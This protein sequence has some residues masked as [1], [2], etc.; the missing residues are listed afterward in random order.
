MMNVFPIPALRD[1]YIWA[2]H[3]GSDAL[4]VDPGVAAPV[5]AWLDREKMRLAAILITHHHGDHTGGMP[6]LRRLYGVPVMGPAGNHISGIDHPLREGDSV[7]PTEGF[8]EFEAWAVPGHTLDHIAYYSPG[9]L[10]CGDTLFSGGCGRLFEGNADQLYQA[11]SRFAALPGNTR[12]FPAHE[13]TA[14]NLEFARTVLPA[15]KKL[16][17]ALANTLKIRENVE[18]TLPSTV[19]RERDIN[20]FMRTEEPAVRAA[21]EA[22]AGR[23]L[24][25]G[26]EVLAALRQWKDEF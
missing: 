22:H 21:A 26:A 7:L 6:E 5:I 4:I 24:E 17:K 15:D 11:L 25:S 12:I 9:Y 14:A 19:A 23:R 18:P 10:F 2:M 3:T 13:Y 1:N 20:V 8:P 16:E